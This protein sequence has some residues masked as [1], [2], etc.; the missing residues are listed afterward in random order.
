MPGQC[1]ARL[2]IF[3]WDL[4]RITVFPPGGEEAA[5][6]V[7]VRSGSSGM[8]VWI[9]RV[10]GQTLYLAAYRQPFMASDPSSDLE[11]KPIIIRSL[12]QDGTMEQD[13]VLVF[14]SSPPLLNA[15]RRLD[16]GQKQ[17]VWSGERLSN[18][19]RWAIVLWMVGHAWY[20]DLLGY[21]QTR[22][23]VFPPRWSRRR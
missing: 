4:N 1:C 18:G 17:P 6:S 3:D 15:P 22:G 21:W 2:L 20:L 14:P 9:S 13:S 10:P 5:Y 12:G 16:I 11:P 23:W 19:V 8:P 7:S